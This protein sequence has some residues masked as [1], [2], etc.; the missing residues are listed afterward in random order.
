MSQLVQVFT[1]AVGSFTLHIPVLKHLLDPE[2]I[3]RK[4]HKG[5][6]L[7]RLVFSDQEIERRHLCKVRLRSPR[8]VSEM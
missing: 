3:H 5:N 4:E 8:K 2:Y 7:Y 1:V 6:S